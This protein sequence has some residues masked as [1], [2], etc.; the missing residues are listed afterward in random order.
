MNVGVVVMARADSRRLPGKVLLDVAGRPLLARVIG[1]ARGVAGEPT[2]VV[3]TSDR[4][5]D[6]PV[7]ELAGAEGVPVYR[8]AAE[9]VLGRL[10]G[11]RDR[12]GFDAVVRV[13]GDSPFWDPTV[14][15]AV[16]A[17]L[18]PGVDL[19]TNVHPRSFPIGMSAEALPSASLTRLGLLARSAAD[20]EHVTW[21]AYR[22]DSGF[23]IANVA[24]G[25]VDAASVRLVVDDARDLARAR[26]IA[27]QTDADDGL[28]NVLELARDW[29]RQNMETVYEI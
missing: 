24:S 18:Q 21:A 14:G 4:P 16:L 3:A 1:R 17:E 12:F 10:T 13:S 20:R 27:A 5:I 23:R 8:G 2:V 7:A 28:A 25:L 26:W 19:A 22:D 6:D 11:A 29:D 9:D 15:S